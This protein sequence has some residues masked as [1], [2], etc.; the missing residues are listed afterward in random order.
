MIHGECRLE[1]TSPWA[2]DIAVEGL[3]LH[4]DLHIVPRAS[5]ATSGGGATAALRR[6]SASL[7]A[8][9][10][11]ISVRRE[12][13]VVAGISVLAMVIA[14]WSTRTPSGSH[15]PNNGTAAAPSVAKAPE[16]SRP[17]P[18]GVPAPLQ[19]SGSVTPIHPDLTSAPASSTS[20]TSAPSPTP[21]EEGVTRRPATTWNE[22]APPPAALPARAAKSFAKPPASARARADSTGRPPRTSATGAREGVASFGA[23]AMPAERST[24]DMLD[25]FGDTK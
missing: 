17:R 25:L 14:F 10:L 12:R 2:D 19:P 23:S 8:L 4:L 13:A 15:A 3:R 16:P 11:G 21:H 24:T 18:A 5:R 22:A 9:C 7:R 6:A 1:A 20:P